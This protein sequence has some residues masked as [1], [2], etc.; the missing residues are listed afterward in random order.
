MHSPGQ[1]SSSYPRLPT[2]LADDGADLKEILRIRQLARNRKSCLPCRE[3]KVRCNRGHPCLTCA[4]RGH[5]DL[6]SYQAQ[7]Q[8]SPGQPSTRVGQSTRG[9]VE[10]ILDCDGTG[11]DVS[12]TASRDVPHE[13]SRTSIAMAANA[14]NAADAI[15]PVTQRLRASPSTMANDVESI[16]LDGSSIVTIARRNSPP[17][18][19]DPDRRSAFET[20]ILPLLGL[21]EACMLSQMPEA[22]GSS[23]YSTFPNDQDLINLFECY[24]CRVH[25]FSFITYDLDQIEK[26]LCLFIN[27]RSKS[28]TAARSAEHND[29][30]W[31]CL[32]HAIVASGAQ[33]SDMP[34]ERRI[35]LSKNHSG[36]NLHRACGISELN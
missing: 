36:S 18:S 25:P 8:P 2:P 32:L 30:R 22:Q 20:G 7:S 19:G 28:D 3:R 6:C 16:L 35:S 12:T 4:K 1:G 34:L 5:P 24:R 29:S 17:L 11:L 33:F 31:L 23:S 15:N 9:T 27:I 10:T 13:G 21:S 26:K 14:A